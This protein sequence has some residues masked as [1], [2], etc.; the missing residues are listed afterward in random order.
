MTEIAKLIALLTENRYPFSVNYQ[1]GKYPL[2]L[3]YAKTTNEA[4]LFDVVCSPWSYGGKE[5]LLEMMDRTYYGGIFENTDDEVLGYLTAEEAFN[6][7][8]KYS[9]GE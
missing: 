6:Y 4:P 9:K 1:E 3:G 8:K 7:I 5:G 2:I